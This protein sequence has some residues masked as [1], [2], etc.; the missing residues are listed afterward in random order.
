MVSELWSRKI[1]LLGL[2]YR[3]WSSVKLLPAQLEVSSSDPL[4]LFPPPLPRTNEERRIFV[5]PNSSRAGKRNARCAT[6]RLFSTSP[7]A[8]YRPHTTIPSSL[9]LLQ[10][11]TDGALWS[12]TEHRKK[13]IRFLLSS[14]ESL[15]FQR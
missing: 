5:S 6:P 9:S 11:S 12:D 10:I 2:R 14:V 15:F 13:I 7:H 3:R 8:S 4:F 1:I